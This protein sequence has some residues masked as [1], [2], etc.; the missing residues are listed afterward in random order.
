VI[1]QT[2]RP[3]PVTGLNSEKW[4]DQPVEWVQFADLTTTQ[5][6]VDLAALLFGSRNYSGD[7]Y[8]HVV[9]W[10]GQKFLEDG[11]TRMA[12]AALLGATGM[13]CRI[14]QAS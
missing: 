7:S 13:Q 6:G 3:Y 14:F 9:V 2:E 4:R 1:I 5:D 8:P 12:R 11:H 10:E